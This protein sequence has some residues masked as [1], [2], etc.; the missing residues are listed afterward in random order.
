M[1]IPRLVLLIAA[2]LPLLFAQGG[3]KPAIAGTWTGQSI[4]QQK[5]SACRDETV[6]YRISPLPDKPGLFSVI[7]DKVVNGKAEN[8]GTLVFRYVEDQHALICENAQG[9]WRFV[10]EGQGMTGTLIRQD[11]TLF[12]RVSMRKAPAT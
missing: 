7:A 4:C 3:S 2:A 1:A 11:G 10:V 9:V 8:M 12:R 6:I 5:E